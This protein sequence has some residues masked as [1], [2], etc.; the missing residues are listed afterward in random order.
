MKI[1]INKCYGGFGLSPFGVKEY[2]KRKG[3]E[4]YFYKQ[5]KYSFQ[6]SGKNGKNEYVKVN[7]PNEKIFTI[8]C[9]TKDYGQ[10]IT[11]KTKIDEGSYFYYGYIER[12]D[13]DL[14]AIVE[15]YGDKVSGYLSNLKVVEIPDGVKWEIDDYDGVE[16]IEEIHNSWG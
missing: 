1:V 8:Y 16:S 15:K 2:L 12:T 5:T 4:A 10:T 9:Y 14:V 6:K 7:N 11:D 13:P 3:K